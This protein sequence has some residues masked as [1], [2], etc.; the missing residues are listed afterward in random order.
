MANV[1]VKGVKKSF[2]AVEMVGLATLI[3]RFVVPTSRP[4]A[5]CLIIT[6]R[7]RP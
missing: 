6:D 7:S 5:V 2:E 3:I 1:E 4:T